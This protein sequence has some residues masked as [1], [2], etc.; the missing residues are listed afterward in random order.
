MTKLV[1]IYHEQIKVSPILLKSQLRQYIRFKKTYHTKSRKAFQKV[2]EEQTCLKEGVLLLRS[3]KKAITY[4]TAE[5]ERMFSTMNRIKNQVKNR[6]SVEHT[7]ERIRNSVHLP[8][9]PE[10]INWG[11]ALSIFKNKKRR[12]IVDL[13]EESEVFKKRKRL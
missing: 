5:N 4:A 13:N 1:E 7:D 10:F 9:N 6:L 3:K 12:Y 8:R 2:I 11:K